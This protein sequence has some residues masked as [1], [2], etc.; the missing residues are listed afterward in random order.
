ML[1]LPTDLT[2]EEN[3][4]AVLL[5]GFTHTALAALLSN[6]VL[7][8]TRTPAQNGAMA[9]LIGRETYY[10]YASGFAILHSPPTEIPD[11]VEQIEAPQVNEETSDE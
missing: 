4:A 10:A 5:A 1:T 7:V 3:D 8:T 11:Y 6:P 9:A 2:I